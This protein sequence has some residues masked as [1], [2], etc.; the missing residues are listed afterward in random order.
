MV[1]GLAMMKGKF[2]MDEGAVACKTLTLSKDARQTRALY[3]V[4][5]MGMTMSVGDEITW[6][7]AGTIAHAKTAVNP[8]WEM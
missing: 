8:G 4:D 1:K 7:E 3:Q 2:V 5:M 6:T